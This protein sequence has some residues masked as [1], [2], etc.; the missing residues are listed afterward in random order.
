MVCASTDGIYVIIFLCLTRTVPMHFDEL[1]DCSKVH[2][3]RQLLK[4]V[5]WSRVV[6]DTVFKRKI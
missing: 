6:P 2:S 1:F 4:T 3:N 5:V